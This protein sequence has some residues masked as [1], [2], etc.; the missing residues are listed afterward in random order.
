MQGKSIGIERENSEKK[1]GMKQNKKKKKCSKP[2][3]IK[4]NE[5]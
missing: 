2:S 5:I 1:K 3:R 4:Q